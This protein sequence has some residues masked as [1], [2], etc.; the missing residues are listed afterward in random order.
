V[1]VVPVGFAVAGGHSRR[2]GEDKASLA[3]GGS[4]L[5]DHALDR[6][7]AVC[8]HVRILSG[9]HPR[10]MDRGVPVLMDERQECGPLA[11]LETA[12][13]SLGGGEIAVLLAVDLP[14]VPAA[15]LER[16]VALADGVDAVVPRTDRG[17]EPLAAV[18]TSGCLP[19]LRDQLAAGERQMTSFHPCC[20]VRFVT[21]DELREWGDPAETFLNVNTPRDYE[22]V[23]MLGR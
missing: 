2:M 16:L 4:T 5:L 17:L 23:R 10:Y 8:A 18:Y 13:A 1:S 6:L 20:A 15:L 9:P 12:L 14:L 3:W 11:G 21:A 22:R 7:R 19:A